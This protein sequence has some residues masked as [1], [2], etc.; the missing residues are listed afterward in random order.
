MNDNSRVVFLDWMRCI[1]CLMVLL[2]HSVEPFYLGDGGTLIQ[3]RSDAIWCTVVDS[4]L[5]ACIGLFVMASSYLLV[6]LKYDARS[7]FRKRFVRVLIPFVIWSVLYALFMPFGKDASSAVEALKHLVFNLNGDSG[8]LWFVYMLLGVYLVMPIVSPWLERATKREEEV[9]LTL[10]LFTSLVPFLRQAAAL[11]TGSTELWGEA[12]W[13]E[14]GMLYNVSGFMGYV[15]LGHYFKKYV[16]P[17]SWGRT[18][19]VALPLWVVGYAITAAWFWSRIPTAYPVRDAIDLAVDMEQSWRFCSTGVVMQTIAYFLLFRKIT[20]DGA[21]YRR[22]VLPI[23]K[24]SYGMYLLHIFVLVMVFP[25]FNALPTPLHM[26][27]CAATTY[28]IS[29]VIAL[30]LQR[31]PYIGKYLAG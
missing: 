23:S 15:L 20:S 5:R 11:V 31:I 18:L 21:F 4:P 25:W 12:N 2:V 8:H 28:V 6:P 14:F 22:V 3:T 13:N 30:L 7:F 24:A 29:A 1:A 9:F 19:A 10:W 26:L 16:G 27:A 17:L